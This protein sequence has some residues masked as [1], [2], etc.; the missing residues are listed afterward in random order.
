MPGSFTPG[1]A[2]RHDD[3]AFAL[4]RAFADRPIGF[5]PADLLARIRDAA[6]DLAP[7]HFHPADRD[8]N[9]TDGWDPLDANAAPFIDPV[10]AARAAGYAEGL[11]AANAGAAKAVERDR[12]LLDDLL[13]A[14]RADDRIDRD[15]IAGK[16][17]QT[18][19][20]LVGKLV[21][22]IGISADIL[23]ARIEAAASLLAD[24][25]ESAMLRVH[26][27]DVALLDGRLPSTIFAVGDEAVARG[28]F[29]LEAA[30]TIV[31]DGP[32][33]WL[34]QLTHAI[35]RVAVPKA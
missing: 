6:P 13:A 4:R 19:T 27:D 5:A 24:A 2:S 12:A 10:E 8:S 25:T 33:L 30:S 31:E 17:R 28:S 9:P 16:L 18:V 20:F 35:D 7:K 22:E 15:A 14:L 1:L 34:E 26:P 23:A 29:V 32:D 21:G 3:A 11:A